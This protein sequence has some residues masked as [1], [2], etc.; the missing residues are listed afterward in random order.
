MEKNNQATIIVIVGISGD[1]SKRKLLPAISKIAEAG[2]L[3]DKFKIVGV[4]RKINTDISDLLVKTKNPDIIKNNL[5]LFEMGLTE[6]DDYL[7]LAEHL[8]KIE[9]DFGEP[10]QRLF[11]L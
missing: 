9:L 5:E 8:L 1:L 3:P 10:A 6:T 4:T 11:Y 7:K 2:R